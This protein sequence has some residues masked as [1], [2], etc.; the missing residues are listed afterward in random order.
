[1]LAVGHVH[2]AAYVMH[3]VCSC[4]GRCM[5]EELPWQSAQL[6]VIRRALCD[7]QKNAYSLHGMTIDL[8]QGCVV[9]LDPRFSPWKGVQQAEINSLQTEQQVLRQLVYGLWHTLQHAHVAFS[10]KSD[11]GAPTSGRMR[12]QAFLSMPVAWDWQHPPHATFM[13]G[14]CTDLHGYNPP[15]PPSASFSL[16]RFQTSEN[17]V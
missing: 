5:H 8:L 10:L 12:R 1:M 6:F 9:W 16:R 17:Y 13:A 7:V 14:T 4:C 2:P 15:P 11:G 3:H